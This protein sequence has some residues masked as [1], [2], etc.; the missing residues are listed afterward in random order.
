[1]DLNS[2][3]IYTAKAEG[4]CPICNSKYAIGARIAHNK[5][6]NSY[7]HA[8]CV[9][10]N[11]N[12]GNEI[13]R[14]PG[15]HAPV[16]PLNAN[17]NPS[18]TRTPLYGVR[19]PA[20]VNKSFTKPA[21]SHTA[22]TRL[23]ETMQTNNQQ[24]EHVFGVSDKLTADGYDAGTIVEYKPTEFLGRLRIS[25]EEDRLVPIYAGYLKGSNA[26]QQ[27][28]LGIKNEVR[29]ARKF[30]IKSYEELL[31]RTLILKVVNYRLAPGFVLVG[32]K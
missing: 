10:S 21:D 26:K 18:F 5:A 14:S 16:G 29:A 1:M 19:Q 24:D 22:N 8:K 9:I 32:V 11:L 17:T 13:T 7:G 12:A 28:K 4:I 3:Y 31:N 27:F 6:T 15:A 25:I 2:T 30:G 20:A 23:G